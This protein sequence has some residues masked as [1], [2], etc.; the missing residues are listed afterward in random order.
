MWNQKGKKTKNLNSESVYSEMKLPVL[1]YL[2]ITESSIESY[3]FK[4]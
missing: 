2:K 1:M 4:I 3:G